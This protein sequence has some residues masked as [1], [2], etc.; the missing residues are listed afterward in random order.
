MKI[1]GVNPDMTVLDSFNWKYVD[2]GDEWQPNGADAE[3]LRIV[4]GIEV[5][6][7]TMEEAVPFKEPVDLDLY[8]DYCVAVA[9]P[10][11]L[12]TIKTK[13]LNKFYP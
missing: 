13:L 8:P 6:M 2:P 9:M 3:Q 4:K 10:T 12:S 7:E 5:V 11:D 1:V